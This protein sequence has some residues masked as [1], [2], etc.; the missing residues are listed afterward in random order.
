MQEFCEFKMS[1]RGRGLIYGLEITQNGMTASEISREAFNNG[2]IIEIAGA[3]NNVLK[4]LPPLII[5]EK[6]LC[7]G[8]EII[9]ESIQSVI[10][11]NEM[12]GDLA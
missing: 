11:K 4:F 7:K 3:E 12:I 5:E 6:M 2:L 9:K 10:K 8:M 1:F